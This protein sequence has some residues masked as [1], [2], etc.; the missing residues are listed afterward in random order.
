MIV[1]LFVQT[2]LASVTDLVSAWLYAGNPDSMAID[3]LRAARDGLTVLLAAWGAT[4]AHRA[5]LPFAFAVL[6]AALIAAY[7]VAGGGNGREEIMVA[8]ATKLL[9]PVLLMATGFGVLDTPGALRA[10]GGWLAALACVSTAFGAWDIDHTEFWTNT[11][12]FGHYLA[13]VKGI[14]TGFDNYYVLPHN[15]FGYLEQ[16]RAAGIV[17]APLAQGSFVAVGALA[18]FAILR[19]HSFALAA[20]VLTVGMFGVWQ[21]GT[22]GA[23]LMMALALPLYLLVGGRGVSAKMRNLALLAVVAAATFQSLSYVYSYSANLEDGSTI[24]HVEALARNIEDLDQVLL[25]GPGLGASGSVAADVGMEIAG[26]G[27]GALFAIIYQIGL[28][29]GVI[30]LLLYLSLAVT[31]MRDLGPLEAGGRELRLMC[32]ALL[33]GASTSLISS[34]HVFSLSGMGTFWILLGGM[35]AQRPAPAAP[36]PVAA[37]EATA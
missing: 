12:E 11:L 32:F 16:R 21:S 23:M 36:A 34:D 9:L 7:A 14:V 8:S 6:Y 24:G 35:L 26:G 20:T 10:Y 27:E 28:P 31:A 4:K 13:G 5:R 22:R 37:Q 25:T 2:L 17:A 1:L 18:G 30:F 33:A 3:V 19:R 29:G 15:F